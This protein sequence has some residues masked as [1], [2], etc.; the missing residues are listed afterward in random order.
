LS[1][2]GL[3]P[4]TRHLKAQSQKT[5]EIK[6]KVDQDPFGKQL[7]PPQFKR[8]NLSPAGIAQCVMDLFAA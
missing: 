2:A 7:S 5:T 1:A 8:L 4:E 3:T 6:T